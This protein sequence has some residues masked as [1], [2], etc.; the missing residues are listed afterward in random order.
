M[1]GHQ[2]GLARAA[3]WI[4][5]ALL[6]TMSVAA[7]GCGDSSSASEQVARF[8]VSTA[9]PLIERQV[10]VGPRPAGSPQLRKLALQLRP[11]LPAGHF[12]AIPGEPRLRNIIGSLPGRRP[13]IVVGA[14][15]DTLV[16][17]RGFVGA[18]SGAASAAAVIGIARALQEVPR[19]SNSREVRFALFDGEEPPRVPRASN[20]FEG[21]R[22]SSAYVT[23]HPGET[24]AMILVDCIA[25]KNLSLSNK[26]FSPLWNQTLAAAKTAGTS[27]YFSNENTSNFYD[28]QVSFIQAGIPAIGLIDWSYPCGSLSDGIDKL[29]R[30][31]LDAMGETVLT[32]LDRLQRE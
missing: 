15:Y 4:V 13:A 25:G 22:G 8:D 24:K 31:S 1:S 12:E 16:K 5:R 21:L 2:S 7:I 29:S 18:N 11:L 9:W 3:S 17:P 28:S 14:H 26:S 30:R 23:A 10:A 32:L 20:A 27:R 19:D 6:V